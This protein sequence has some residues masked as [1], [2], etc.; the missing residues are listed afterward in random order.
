VNGFK[1]PP[2]KYKPESSSMM[3]SEVF[4]SDDLDLR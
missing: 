2:K 4:A 3:G 1:V